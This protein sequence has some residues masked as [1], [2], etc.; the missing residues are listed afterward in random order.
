MSALDWMRSRDSASWI[1]G[2]RTGLY[3][4]GLQRSVQDDARGRCRAHLGC[5]FEIEY[6]LV[7]EGKRR[8]WVGESK[9]SEAGSEIVVNVGRASAVR[10][11]A[12][13]GGL[14]LE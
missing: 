13:G 6:G 11:R 14:G 7:V 8:C 9:G 5:G 1:S 12:M 4:A 10:A 2:G 3:C